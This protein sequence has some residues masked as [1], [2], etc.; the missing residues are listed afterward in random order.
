MP[1]NR[2][3][4]HDFKINRNRKKMKVAKIMANYTLFK[5]ILLVCSASLFG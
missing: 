5:K 2:L 1:S 4:K 3:I